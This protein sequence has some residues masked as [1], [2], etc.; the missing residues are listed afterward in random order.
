MRRHE[1]LLLAL[2]VLAL[3]GCNRPISDPEQLRAIRG[4]AVALMQTHAPQ[5]PLAYKE[6]EERDWPPAIARLHPEVIVVHRW[7][8]DI[9]TTGYFDG[10]WGYEVPRSKADL[11]MPVACYA[12]LS[13]GVFWH[14]PC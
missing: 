10:G 1:A 5:P 14:G 8:V 6:V 7:G 11:P 13:E 3:A 12:E 2:G 4:E 9:I